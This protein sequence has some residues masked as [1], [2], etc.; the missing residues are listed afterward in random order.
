MNKQN[1]IKEVKDQMRELADRLE[2]LETVEP[3]RE[4][5]MGEVWQGNTG[6][7]LV[8]VTEG[9]GFIQQSDGRVFEQYDQFSSLYTYVGKAKDVLM[10]RSEASVD[11]LRQRLLDW[12][13][14]DGDG[15]A[16]SNSDGDQFADF[17]QSI[18]CNAL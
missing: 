6:L 12:R 8:I 13:D 11:D 15:I 10:L 14:G 17:A 2:A 18:L 1:E 5:Q 4:P 16:D 9:G 3:K 7:G